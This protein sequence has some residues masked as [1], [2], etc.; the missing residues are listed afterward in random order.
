MSDTFLSAFSTPDDQMQD[1][2]L[3]QFKQELDALCSRKGEPMNAPK[4]I[5][6]DTAGHEPL[7]IRVT[8]DM[9]TGNCLPTM[10][11]EIIRAYMSLSS[12]NNELFCAGLKVIHRGLRTLKRAFDRYGEA[13]WDDQQ[14]DDL[15]G[16]FVELMDE[17][18]EEEDRMTNDDYGYAEAAAVLKPIAY[19]GQYT[20]QE[21]LKANLILD[22]WEYPEFEEYVHYA[23][24]R[25]DTYLEENQ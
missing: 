20:K 13:Y 23:L 18:P 8:A 3:D 14:R 7:V 4:F 21:N 6:E 9:L 24:R 12:H 17:R 19:S 16:G 1:I 15:P 25:I 10:W 5:T 22:L 2:T 11:Q